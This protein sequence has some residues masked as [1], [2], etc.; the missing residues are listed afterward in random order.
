MKLTILTHDKTYDGGTD[1]LLSHCNKNNIVLNG[2]EVLYLPIDRKILVSKEEIEAYEIM[3]KLMGEKFNRKN[4]ENIFS[5]SDPFRWNAWRKEK[6][7]TS[8]YEQLLSIIFFILL[9]SNK[10]ILVIDH[11]EQNLH[12]LTTIHLIRMILSN[13]DFSDF[14]FTTYQESVLNKYLIE[15]KIENVD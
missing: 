2:K 8:G 6:V 14:I 9:N 7:I 5:I 15:G 10:K 13:F 1:R 3:S 4:I 12:V 11:I